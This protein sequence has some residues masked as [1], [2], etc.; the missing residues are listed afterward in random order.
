MPCVFRLEFLFVNTDVFAISFKWRTEGSFSRQSL[1]SNLMLTAWC[2]STCHEKHKHLYSKSTVHNKWDKDERIT[3]QL[4]WSATF[5]G[6]SCLH[7]H[8]S[9]TSWRCKCAVSGLCGLTSHPCVY[10][11]RILS[12]ESTFQSPV[13][14]FYNC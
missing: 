7:S 4:D 10:T 6:F 13:N 8:I 2:I 14:I 12:M 5:W 11:D 1:T 3:D 9:S